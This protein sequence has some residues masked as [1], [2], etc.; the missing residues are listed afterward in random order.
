MLELR[1]REE[2]RRSQGFVDRLR[3]AEVGGRRR[4][5]L[6]ATAETC[7]KPAVERRQLA[8]VESLENGEHLLCLRGIPERERALEN[9]GSRDLDVLVLQRDLT[10]DAGEH[11]F[12][13][14]EG[15]AK[16]ALRAEDVR[17]VAAG[18][19]VALRVLGQ[20]LGRET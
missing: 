3:L 8:R 4:P 20:L 2:E 16:L 1:D 15:L 14:R 10:L 17:L 5:R 12:H 9:L 13:E 11:P 6:E 7:P 18:G 19:C